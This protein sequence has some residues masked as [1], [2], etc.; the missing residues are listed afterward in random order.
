MKGR[1][2]TLILVSLLIAG[3]LGGCAAPAPTAAP[4]ATAAP[5]ATAAPQAEA[6]AEKPLKV[7]LVVSTSVTDSGWDSTAYQAC[8]K[9]RRSRALKSR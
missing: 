1:F 9:V 6:P 5:A 8:S 7:A 2:L 4:Q 3:V